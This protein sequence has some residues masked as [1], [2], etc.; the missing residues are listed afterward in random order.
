M[1]AGFELDHVFVCVSNLEDS[2]KMLTDR[3]LQ[4]GVRSV[5]AG[6]GTADAVFFFD[7]AYLELLYARDEGKLELPAARKL[8]LGRRLDWQKSGACPFGVAFRRTGPAQE[9][10]PETWD[11]AAPFLPGGA[12]IP[13]MTPA[14]LAREPL[15]LISTV[16]APPASYAHERGIPLEQGGRR[17]VL[18]RVR[19]DVPKAQLSA[20]ARQMAK[21]GLL[22]IQTAAGD[23]HMELRF[24][25]EPKTTLD[26]RPELPLSIVWAA[27]G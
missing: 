23:Y 21:T 25:G 17:R 20:N 13:I 19:I 10:E 15:L 27:S 4:C 9:D 6:Q 26:F 16:S 11:Y 18:D 7:N 1:P 24:D 12:T 14:G 22:E 8:G 3:G 2:V 5:H